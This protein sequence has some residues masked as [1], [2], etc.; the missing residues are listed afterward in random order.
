VMGGRAPYRWIGTTFPPPAGLQI[1]ADGLLSGRIASAGTYVFDGIVTDAAGAT[2]R[3]LVR[4]PVVEQRSLPAPEPL[5]VTDGMAIVRPREYELPF[6]NPL[7]GLRPRPEDA[8]QDLFASLTRKYFEWNLLERDENDGVERIKRITDEAFG[9]LPRYNIKAITRVYLVWPEPVLTR[10]W[11]SDLTPDDYSSPQFRE[12]MKRL[13]ANLGEAWNNDPR[14]AYIELGIIGYWGEHHHPRFNELPREVE[15]EMGDAFRA[16][17]P[18]K[19]LMTRYIDDFIDYPFGMHWDVFGSIVKDGS[20]NNFSDAVSA[21]LQSR[22]P[23]KWKTAPRGG[24]IAPDF[25]GEPDWSQTS[26]E[27]VL[28]KNTPRLIDLIRTLHWNHL[29]AIGPYSPSDA[30]LWDKVGQIQKALSYRF[31]IDEA[32]YTAAMPSSS[33]LAVELK[34]RNAGVTPLYYNWPLEV[35]LHDAETKRVVWRSTWDA[36][37]VRTWLP[38]ETT[39]LSGKF[40]LPALSSKQYVVSLAILD[41]AGMVPAVRFANVNYWSGGR[42]PLG[43]ISIGGSAPAAQLNDFDDLQSD[44][45]LYYL[46]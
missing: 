14:I 3:V 28:R 32:K 39:T 33:E 17:F 4:Q 11:P 35:A 8:K 29:D 20:I 44:R 34:I 30:E 38:G 15:R 36:I 7:G 22:Q 31:V 37:D 2:A 40:A 18:D 19:L 21:A 25:V 16:A 6:R 10:Y 23:N 26:R 5:T 13:I 12:R 1:D 41:P 24:E 46:R 42:T 9:D 43:P 27:N 45:S